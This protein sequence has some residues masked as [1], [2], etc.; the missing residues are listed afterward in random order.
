MMP[1]PT[2]FTNSNA[3]VIWVPNLYSQVAFWSDGR[4]WGMFLALSFSLASDVF[5]SLANRKAEKRQKGK[6]H[7][8]RKFFYLLQRNM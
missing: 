4:G 6:I 7:F 8:P 3:N 2:Y 1:V 5:V